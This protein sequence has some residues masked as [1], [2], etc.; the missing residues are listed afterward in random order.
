MEIICDCRVCVLNNDG[1]V[2]D[3]DSCSLPETD[4]DCS[5]DGDDAGLTYM[6]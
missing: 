6:I 2:I 4:D 3:A 5:E 1:S